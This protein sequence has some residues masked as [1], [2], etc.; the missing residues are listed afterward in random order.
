M[1]CPDY[2][3]VSTWCRQHKF[4]SVF[5]ASRT[6]SQAASDDHALKAIFDKAKIDYFTQFLNV[7]I[8]CDSNIMFLWKVQLNDHDV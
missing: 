7:I 1:F 4:T 2:K 6:C 5:D 8:K 3:C